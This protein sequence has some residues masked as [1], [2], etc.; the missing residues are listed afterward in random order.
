MLSILSL[1]EPESGWDSTATKRNHS[2]YDRIF[3]KNLPKKIS[4]EFHPL[5]ALLSKSSGLKRAVPEN[6]RSKLLY[7]PV[8]YYYNN[9]DPS[10]YQ[11]LSS[12]ASLLPQG[13]APWRIPAVLLI[14]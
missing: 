8:K 4:D 9:N 13:G 3:I 7:N 11:G 14:S 12:L 6:Q 10:F 1:P 5:M 2:L